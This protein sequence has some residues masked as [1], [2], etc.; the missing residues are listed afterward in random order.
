MLSLTTVVAAI[1]AGACVISGSGW[2]VGTWIFAGAALA[3]MAFGI[4]ASLVCVY[5][6]NRRVLRPGSRWA[7]GSDETRIRIDTPATTHVI[8]R[9]KILSARTTGALVI[10]RVRP[11]VTLGLPTALFAEPALKNLLDRP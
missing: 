9:S 5:I 4:M 2:I 3:Y 7:S 6:Q 10:L 1:F 8:D 11:K